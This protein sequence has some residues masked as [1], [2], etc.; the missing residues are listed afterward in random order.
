MWQHGRL[1]E[2]RRPDEE[3]TEVDAAG[4]EPLS[5]PE[6]PLPARD[7]DT[8][9]PETTVAEPRGLHDTYQAIR[10]RTDIIGDVW[11]PGQIGRGRFHTARG[12]LRGFAGKQDSFRGRNL[13]S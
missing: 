11:P 6:I 10:W 5:D 2:I 9:V 4:F 13:A 3:A 7:G 8:L 1:Y 12:P